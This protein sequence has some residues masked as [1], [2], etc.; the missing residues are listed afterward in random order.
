MMRVSLLAATAAATVLVLTGGA[1]AATVSGNYLVDQDHNLQF[2][3]NKQN[4]NAITR[5]PAT[6]VLVAGANDQIGEPLCSGTSTPLASPCPF[7]AGVGVD[8]YYRSTD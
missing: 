4:E 6:G 1:S 2:S 5:D 8:G 3:Q 7:E